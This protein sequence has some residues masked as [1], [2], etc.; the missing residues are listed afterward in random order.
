MKLDGAS[1]HSDAVSTHKLSNKKVY[2]ERVDCSPTYIL[3]QKK[4]NFITWAMLAPMIYSVK[5]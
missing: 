5:S 1:D 3:E 2:T 4:S